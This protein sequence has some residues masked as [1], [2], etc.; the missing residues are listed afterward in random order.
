MNKIILMGRLTC[1]VESKYYVVDQK[2]ECMIRT[3]MAVDRAGQKGKAD[4]FNLVAFGKRAEFFQK[5]TKKGVK[6]LIVGKVQN[7][8]YTNQY[9]QKVNSIQVIVDEVEFAES[10]KAQEQ[11]QEQTTAPQKAGGWMSVPDSDDEQL[12]FN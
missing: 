12:P 11:S 2:E 4:F 6:L 1:D 10:K 3:G 9:G 7:D 5:Y 8:T